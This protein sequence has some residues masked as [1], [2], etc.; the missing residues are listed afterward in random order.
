MMPEDFENDITSEILNAYN[1]RNHPWG[2]TMFMSDRRTL[3]EANIAFV[4]LN[5]GGNE[6]F[7]AQGIFQKDSYCPYRDES[8]A[9]YPIGQAPLQ[10]QVTQLFG[11]FG[12]E[13]AQGICGNLVPFRS[14]A[15]KDLKDQK[16]A[17]DLGERI[18]RKV[19]DIRPRPII[20]CMSHP[21]AYRLAKI[22]GAE[23]IDNPAVGWGRIT[24]SRWQH[25]DGM[26]IRLPHLSRFQLFGN[27]QR[28]RALEEILAPARNLLH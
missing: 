21:V 18:W 22:L 12:Q 14:P 26:L 7:E 19:F 6:F 16:P 8:W 5:P 27:A 17:L 10:K 15:W 2:W 13:P 25:A 3:L 24:A 23:H 28:T 1:K 9:D 20:I 4:G 11:Y